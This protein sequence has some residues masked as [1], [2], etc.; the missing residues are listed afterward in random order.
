MKTVL[1]VLIAVLFSSM[2][3]KA[4]DFEL[5]GIYY[6]FIEETTDEVEVTYFIEYRHDDFDGAGDYYGNILIPESI[7]YQNK[8]YWVTGIGEQAFRE[9]GVESVIIPKSI[10]YIG[11]LAFRDCYSLHRIEVQWETPL[12]LREV[13]KKYPKF[14]DSYSDYVAEDI[15]DFNE[16][17]FE[18][19]VLVVPANTKM[20]YQMEDVWKNFIHI[21]EKMP[22]IKMIQYK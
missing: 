6:N 5:D 14:D 21:E 9:S 13:E 17:D 1:L 22:T 3:A 2:Q 19:V 12:N 4:Y 10:K 15:F 8:E 11:W 18:R 7:V 20:F 16:R